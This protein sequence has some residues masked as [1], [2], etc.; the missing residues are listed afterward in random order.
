MVGGLPCAL[1][2]VC[3]RGG[4]VVVAAEIT[5]RVAAAS[6]GRLARAPRTNLG[7][8]VNRSRRG[9]NRVVVDPPDARRTA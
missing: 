7:A 3:A 9:A 8:E 6:G 4:G 5:I 1:R 2:E